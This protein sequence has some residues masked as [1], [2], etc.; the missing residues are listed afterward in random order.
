MCLC[1]GVE[2]VGFIL[3]QIDKAF[4]RDFGA[5]W[6]TSQCLMH[7][8]LRKTLCTTSSVSERGDMIFRKPQCGDSEYIGSHYVKSTVSWLITL[9]GI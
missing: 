7:C 5:I 2:F 8:V 9:M 1:L 4:G 6:M 3:K